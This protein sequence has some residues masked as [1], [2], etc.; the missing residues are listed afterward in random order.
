M[1]NRIYLLFI[2][3][4]M[5]FLSIS[6]VS[7]ITVSLGNSR[8][9]LRAE[10]GE[11]LEKPLRV[12]NVNDV[13]VTV[14]LIVSGDLEDYIEIEENNFTLSPEEDKKAYF[15]IQSPVKGMSTTKIYVKFTPEEGS[16]VGLASTIT[17]ISGG[18]T[19]PINITSLEKESTSFNLFNF[20]SESK[21]N[22][23]SQ[24]QMSP[25]LLLT[26][27]SAVLLIIFI[28]LVM[29]ATKRQKSAKRPR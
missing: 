20:N 18:S 17:F 15:T 29:Y 6:L 2:A 8:M 16:P 22:N 4:I 3:S 7:S 21:E 26:F 9:V 25:I 12:K 5:V 19:E 28:L 24:F 14:E 10:P 23:P 13:P 1:K 11:I 27:S